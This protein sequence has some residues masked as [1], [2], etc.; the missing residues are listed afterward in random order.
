MNFIQL[1][2][3]I[4]LTYFWSLWGYVDFKKYYITLSQNSTITKLS[5]K[6]STFVAL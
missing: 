4:Y 3:M 2:R 6:V 1:Y 5:L